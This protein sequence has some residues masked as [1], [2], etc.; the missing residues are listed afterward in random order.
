MGFATS[1][2]GVV[3]TCACLVLL[4]CGF[5]VVDFVCFACA[6]FDLVGLIWLICVSFVFQLF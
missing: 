4:W 5:G 1:V 3:A 2:L 6:V